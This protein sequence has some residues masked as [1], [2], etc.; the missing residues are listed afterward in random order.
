MAT[1]NSNI[2]PGQVFDLKELVKYGESAVV[3]RTIIKKDTG[4]R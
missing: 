3:S 2:E 4:S 1:K